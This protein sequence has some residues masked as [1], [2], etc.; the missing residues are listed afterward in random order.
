L[1]SYLS[2]G[3][4]IFA[5]LTVP[6]AGPPAGGY[7]AIVFNHGYIPP[8][9][10]KPTEKYVAYVEAMASRGYVVFRPDYRG[11]GES[12]GRPEGAY[13][14]PA[15]ATD[16][17]NA[18]ASIKKYDQ[19][20]PDKIGMWGHSMGGN[21]TLRDMV[22]RPDE[23]KAAVIWAGVVGSYEDL[24]YNWQRK[25]PFK[26]SPKE[27]ELRNR[28]RQMIMDT[29]G[30]PKANPQFWNSIDPVA[31]VSE[32][33]TPVQLHHGTADPEV[34]LLFSENLYNK[35]TA[36][37]K[38]VEFYTYTGAD[39]NISGKSFSQAMTRTVEFF[40]SYLK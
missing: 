39:H 7:P 38:T 26:P 21:I 36:A 11:N 23:V 18:L 30:D 9:Q 28:Y 22:V 5:L 33:K 16:V 40:D 3:L 6:K 8:E 10:Y 12:E 19:V 32:I 31:F 34:P 35:L 29:Y 1:A 14:S 17:L 20:D 24:M 37:G 13:Y 27:M 4:K 25:V 2:D 15:Y